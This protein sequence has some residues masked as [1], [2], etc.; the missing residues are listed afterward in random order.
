MTQQTP[1]EEKRS[2]AR[3][4]VAVVLAAIAI[5]F[6]FQNSWDAR[7]HFLFWHFTFPAWALLL[8][9]FVLGALAGLLIPK[10]RA[11]SKK[12]R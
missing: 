11:R 2:V 12:K 8:V 6:I 5:I 1:T 10:Y 3:T 7:V 9:V 4:V